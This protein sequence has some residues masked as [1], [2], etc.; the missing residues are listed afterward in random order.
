MT[1]LVVAAHPDDEVLGCGATMA[2]LA[3][4]GENVVLA[5]LGEGA[6]SR[7]A[8]AA[9][10]DRD[11][12]ASLAA[13]SHRAADIL[14]A[15]EVR[16]FGLP[17]NRFDTLPLLDVVKMVEGVIADV[18]PRFVY[19]HHG[20][21][22]NI[23]HQIVFRA[24]LA[25]TRPVP[26]HQVAELYAFEVN[27]STEWAFQRLHPVF[28]PSVF[29]DV[30][31]TLDLK[32]KALEAYSTEVRPFPHPRSSEAVRAAALRWGSTVGVGAAEAFE[33]IRVLR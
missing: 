2:R 17:D 18:S 33:P 21:D 5:I 14:G 4:E 10:A 29:V 25:A 6:T 24:V 19:T 26:G 32:V 3:A 7:Y 9:D 31:D 8:Q 11:E 20:G 15:K 13:D 1:T 16:L 23:D 22:L 27:S 30:T 28:C 12:V